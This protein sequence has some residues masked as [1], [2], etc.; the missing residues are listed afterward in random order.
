MDRTGAL[1]GQRQDNNVQVLGV[2]GH[3]QL[4]QYLIVM[5]E[6]TQPKREILLQ[7]QLPGHSELHPFFTFEEIESFIKRETGFWEWLQ[8]TTASERQLQDISSFVHQQL[9]NLNSHYTHAKGLSD[10]PQAQQQRLQ[11]LKDAFAGLQIVLSESPEAKFLEKLAEKDSVLA[12]FTAGHFFGRN[13]QTNHAKAVEGIFLA[14]AFKQGVVFD[15]LTS[16]L[17]VQKSSL[18]QLRTEYRSKYSEDSK[19]FHELKSDILELKQLLEQDKAKFVEE[20]GHALETAEEKL[21]NI[22]DT[23]DKKL[24]LQSS[25]NYWSTKQGNHTFYSWIF[26]VASGLIALAVTGGI[27]FEIYLLLKPSTANDPTQYWKLGVVGISA[28][29]GIWVC[30]ILVKI[31]LTHI[32]LGN[33]AQERVTMIQTYLALLREGSGP[34]DDQ[35][36][37]ILQTLFRP[38]PTGLVKDDLTPPFLWE[39]VTKIKN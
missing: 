17:E 32:H 3:F 10:N 27:I 39:W 33:D 37:L 7:V 23:Y 25:V 4:K 26:G 6:N 21:K 9:N 12:G 38:S 8:K 24:A 29:F 15:S 16:H 18:D 28:F 30:R 19:E 14:T 1:N 34:S 35:K 13:P 36:E 20:Q 31:F 2:T 22:Q 11:Q 5:S